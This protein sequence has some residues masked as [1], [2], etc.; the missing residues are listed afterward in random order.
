[1][2]SGYLEEAVSPDH[3]NNVGL[4]VVGDTLHAFTMEN[5]DAPLQ[6]RVV[7]W[8]TRASDGSWKENPDNGFADAV[9]QVSDAPTALCNAYLTQDDHLYW[10]IIAIQEGAD[11]TSQRYLFEVQDGKATLLDTPPAGEISIWMDDTTAFMAVCGDTIVVMDNGMKPCAYDSQGNP[12]QMEFPEF[13]GSGRLLCGNAGGFYW[14]DGENNLQYS[15][16][17]GTTAETVLDGSRY[18]LTSPGM[19]VSSAAVTANDTIYIQMGDGNTSS[20]KQFLYRYRWDDTLQATQGGDLTVFSLYE[21][22]TV[23]A[24]VD[25]M[26]KQTGAN[27]T[28]TYAL[29]ESTEQGQAVVSGSREDALTQLNTQLLAGSGPDVIILDDMPVQ[30][31]IE[32]GVLAD[33]TGKV[34]IDGLLPNMAGVWT[35]ETGLYAVPA[36]CFPLLFG[37]TDEVIN[38]IPDAETLA[39]QLASEP[40]INQGEYDWQTDATPL[41]MF[42]NTEQLFDTFSPLS[43]GRIWQGGELN[44]E[45]CRTFVEMMGKI[46]QGGGST[47]KG[48][49]GEPSAY[50]G[51]SYY[52]PSNGTGASFMNAGS[53]AFCKLEYS[54][55]GLGSYFQYYT[56]L[57]GT[58]TSAIVRPMTMAAGQ[59]C[60]QPPCVAGVNV[61]AQN[62][63][64]AV[65]FLQIL[66][67]KSLQEQ[68]T[69]D[70]FPTLISAVQSQ[71][72]NG[73]A[74]CGIQSST[75][76]MA[77]LQGMDVVQP[78]TVLRSAALQAVQHYLNGASM[79]E[80]I[81]T[82]RDGAELWLAEQ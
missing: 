28:Y 81:Q 75:D 27:V 13:N 60:I 8:Y 50:S 46:C 18:A 16:V 7:H 4:Y 64:G 71:W 45:V 2:T 29:E 70:G 9:C 36:R 59:S 58:Q 53:N 24:A 25:E 33:L 44:A 63:E 73:L 6:Q 54:L 10:R 76:M 62:P 79:G 35:T 67:G 15:L 42:Y 61:S 39:Q 30:S 82:A 11:K 65:Q 40:S 37:G 47:L 80:A 57:S 21:S 14:L 32:K 77:V 56:Q 31:M 23:A 1:M 48:M 26:I 43:V 51:T 19:F 72:Q 52:T 5:A 55:G 78:S 49:S 22:P 69:Y 17:G 20:Q 66:L 74:S 3:N 12:V 38:T 68:N 34:N 41:M